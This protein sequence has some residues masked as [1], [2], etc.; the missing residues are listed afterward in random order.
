MGIEQG[1]VWLDARGTQSVGHAERGIARYV[2]E[3][4]EALL[5]I[6]P[7]LIGWVG[8][9]PAMPTPPSIDPLIGSDRLTW[10]SKA[11][12]AGRKAPPIYHV[13]SPFEADLSLDDIWP[14][15]IR[16]SDSRLVVTLYDLIPLMMRERYLADWGSWATAWVARLGLT[17][18]AHQVLT[19]SRQTAEDAMEHLKIPEERI[20]VID[21]GVSDH[22]A[23]L[24][25]SRAEGSSIV[26]AAYPKIRP[27][28]LLYV[29]GTDYR[30][31]LEGTIRA[32]SEL[33]PALRAQHQLV[34]ACNL[35]LLRR[36]NL[37]AFA[38]GLG[39]EPGRLV[40][41]GFVSDRELAALYRS[42]ELFVFPSLYEGAGLPILEAMS[43]GAPV[44]ASGVSAMPELLG[45][46]EA[47]FD[48]ND[49]SDMAR[50]LREVLE[51][52][53]KLEAL[54]ERSSRRVAI[55]TWK[56]VAERTITGYERAMEIPLE[57]KP[58][59]RSGRR[60]Q[61]QKH[62]AVITPWPPDPSP[63]AAHSKRLV[64]EL[65]EYAAVDVIVAG[66]P[67]VEYDR[68]LEPRVQIRPDS[69]FAW[70]H[71]LADYESCLFVLGGSS[72]HLH[73]LEGSINV[74]GVVLAH[75][76]RL[77]G[78]YEDLG[79]ERF[80]YEQQ[81]L[82]RKLIELYG[83]RMPSDFLKR[84]PFDTPQA[85]QRVTMTQEVQA[86]ARQVLVHSRHQAELLRIEQPSEAAAAEVVPHGIPSAVIRNGARPHGEPFV[87]G[88]KTEGEWPRLL[89]AF[90]ELFGEQ[91]DARLKLIAA[92]SEAEHAAV[93]EM[94]G[95]LGIGEAVT[96]SG[97]LNQESYR[98]LLETADLA[99]HLGTDANGGAAS[100][101]I[102][103]CVGARVPVIA[104]A[105]GWA[106]E[107]PSGVVMT[108]PTDC[109]AAGL[110]NR[111]RSILD[112]EPL[113]DGIREAQDAY[114]TENSFA[115]VAER[116]AE[117]LSL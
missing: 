86:H 111:M 85:K 82:E 17:R 27:G 7:E 110:A 101:A 16:D 95:R 36:F 37:R 40:L 6:A 55:Y 114:A 117:L 49:P 21:S 19:I 32:Y 45:D 56:R 78:L 100:E 113:S 10:Q 64:S 50:C 20:T 9:N 112:D 48:P 25:G 1:S 24:V 12:P 72:D 58:S 106:A 104:S 30:K 81:W 77:L 98:R 65:S 90:A 42:C 69:D 28:F 73:A 53:G 105:I 75:D 62:L 80:P 3:Q 93:A 108:V 88:F 79:R 14:A 87:L 29:G 102:C 96:L 52:P 103:D 5:E 46:M 22:H 4:A 34:I 89:E 83:G 51:T 38:R 66:D 31:N 115:R 41:T 57:T 60:T 26:R 59:V 54:R 13:M 109:S 76:V 116:Y 35:P 44:A 2:A 11:Q 15:W 47:T 33:P 94:A 39:V 74:P 107:L 67:A 68:S 23:S 99:V 18:S 43:C 61:R 63:A 91:P 84:L 70:M 8:L 92:F 71:E 97:R